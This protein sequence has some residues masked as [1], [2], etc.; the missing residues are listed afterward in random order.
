MQNCAL[1]LRSCVRACIPS[2]MSHHRPEHTSKWAPAGI[3]SAWSCRRPSARLLFRPVMCWVLGQRLDAG[4]PWNSCTRPSRLN[5]NPARTAKEKD[6]TSTL[7]GCIYC[8]LL[9]AIL[10][11]PTHHVRRSTRASTATQ[12]VCETHCCC[13]PEPAQSLFRQYKRVTHDLAIVNPSF[14]GKIAPLINN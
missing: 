10:L 8:H 9:F 7:K 6:A 13:E 5:P 3:P 2:P 1:R 12:E 14:E 4:T 11:W